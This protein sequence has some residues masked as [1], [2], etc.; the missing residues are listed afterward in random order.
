MRQPSYIRVAYISSP[1]Y[2]ATDFQ[3]PF[4]TSFYE[5]SVW[6]MACILMQD[7]KKEKPSHLLEDPGLQS[8]G[9]VGFSWG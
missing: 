8:V 2:P 9:L 7:T 6:E 5:K 1:N 4:L 3:L